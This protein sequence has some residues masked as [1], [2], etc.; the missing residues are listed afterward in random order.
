M[1]ETHLEKIKSLG[2]DIRNAKFFIDINEESSIFAKQTLKDIEQK[3]KKYIIAISVGA[4]SHIKR[5]P[6]KN[7]LEI[8]K[9][10]ESRDDVFLIFVGDQA[11][12]PLVREVLSG[13]DK[14]Y[15]DLSGKTS[16]L[17]LAA[18]LKGCDFLLCNDSAIMHM[19]SA[20]ETPLIALFG[21]TDHRKYG[22]K[23]KNSI[24]IHKDIKC[25]PC[26]KAQCLYNHECLDSISSQEVM[27]KIKVMI[28]NLKK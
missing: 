14:N 15:L 8:S 13:I 11:D 3:N 24:L 1:K 27:N 20:V 6:L 21:P 5:W 16:L 17:E 7:F 28:E 22:P 26:Q 25:A 9:E 19:A 10:L 2:F 12:K 23:G 18:I 4:R